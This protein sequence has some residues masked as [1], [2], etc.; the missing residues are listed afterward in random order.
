MQIKKSG[1][2]HST[3]KNDL[4]FVFHIYQTLKPVY[5]EKYYKQGLDLH[6]GNR[7]KLR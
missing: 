4:A 7:M 5:A 2:P 6:I 1:S 3:Q